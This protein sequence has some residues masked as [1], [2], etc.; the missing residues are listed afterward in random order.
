MQSMQCYAI[1][2][3]PAIVNDSRFENNSAVGDGGIF[4][5]HVS[6]ISIYNSSFMLNTAGIF[7]IYLTNL[8]IHMSGS[9]PIEQTKAELLLLWRA[10]S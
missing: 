1:I 5:V 9:Y 2:R 6:E 8:S 10:T 4:L 7:N 3:E